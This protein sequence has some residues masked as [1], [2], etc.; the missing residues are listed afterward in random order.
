MADT[1]SKQLHHATTSIQPKEGRE[2]HEIPVRR[3]IY[4]K[5]GE[6]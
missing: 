6:F 2:Y 1:A 5:G 4:N 3:T